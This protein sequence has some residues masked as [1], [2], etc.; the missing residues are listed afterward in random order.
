[1]SSTNTPTEKAKNYVQKKEIPQLFEALMTG[2]MFK[3]PDDHIEFLI[4][5]LNNLKSAG[6][7]LPPIKWNTFIQSASDVATPLPPVRP[8]S[9]QI[10]Q[11]AR[12]LSAKAL[13][14]SVNHLSMSRANSKAEMNTKY[15]QP[16]PSITKKT[17]PFPVVFMIGNSFK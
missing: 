9:S 8:G 17:I 1:M 10:S 2:L 14:K 5:C 4:H 16:L 15:S 7:N 12:I 3:Q 6:K 13:D 11:E